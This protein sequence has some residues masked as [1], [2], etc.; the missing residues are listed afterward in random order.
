MAADVE[1]E[2]AG[3]RAERSRMVE[4][5]LLSRGIR[6][7]RVLQAMRTVPREDFTPAFLRPFAYEDRPHPIGY[8]QTIS[9]P[10]IVALMTEALKLKGDERVLEIGTGSG[11][12]TAVL[13]ELAAEIF[14]IERIPELSLRAELALEKLAY[15]N[16]HLRVANGTFGWPEES[17]FHAIIVTAGATKLPPAYHEQLL[18][19]GRLVIPLGLPGNQVLHCFRRRRDDW[20]DEPLGRVAFVPLVSDRS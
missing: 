1:K 2:S 6:D 7:R 17:P 14:S 13:A 18:E 10:C 5:Q 16:I 4:E 12:Q 20:D 19:E 3:Y 11:Y 9:Q 15:H 8:D